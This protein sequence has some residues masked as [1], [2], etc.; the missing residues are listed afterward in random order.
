MLTKYPNFSFFLG[1]INN[2]KDI[3]NCFRQFPDISKI[4]H[5][6]AQA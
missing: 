2:I 4:C 6:A 1:D 5:L 3:E